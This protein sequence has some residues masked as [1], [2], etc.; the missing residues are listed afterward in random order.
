EV[1]AADH[2]R[3]RAVRASDLFRR[4]CG[5]CRAILGLGSLAANSAWKRAECPAPGLH[6]AHARTAGAAP[7]SWLRSQMGGRES[8]A[9]SRR[10]TGGQLRSPRLEVVYV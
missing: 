10:A 4:G 8:H 9:V 1:Q 5:G 2:A 6:P 3:R 7:A